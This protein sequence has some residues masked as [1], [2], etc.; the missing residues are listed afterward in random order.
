MAAPQADDL[1]RAKIA[2][3]SDSIEAAKKLKV[4]Q[5]TATAVAA[6]PLKGL[7]P[8]R[9]LVTPHPDVASGNY[10]QAEFAADLAQVARGEGSKEYVDPREFFS[11]T[12]LTEGL[13][14]PRP[15][16]SDA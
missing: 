2:A 1:L 12:Y 15:G 6:E 5:T 14:P 8:W 11:R 9:T 10:R 16:R 4:Q 3:L 13:R 7:A